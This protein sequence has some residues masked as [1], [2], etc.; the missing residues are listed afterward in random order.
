M[1]TRDLEDLNDDE[2][3]QRARKVHETLINLPRDH[4]SR[5][6]YIISWRRCINELNRRSLPDPVDYG[7]PDTRVPGGSG[8]APGGFYPPA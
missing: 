4:V 8:F 6:D 5:D 7:T 3:A 1:T 2:L